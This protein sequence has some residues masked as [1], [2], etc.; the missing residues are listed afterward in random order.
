VDANIHVLRALV[1]NTYLARTETP[2]ATG[3]QTAARVGAAWRDQN[4]NISG[5]WRRIGDDFRPAVGFV[6]RSDIEHTYVTVGT[7]RRPRVSFLQEVNPYLEVHR[8]TDLG[9]TLVTREIQGGLDLDLR[10]GATLTGTVSHTYELVERPFTLSG[11][12]IAAGGYDFDEGS[13]RFQSSAGKPFSASVALSGGGYYGGE[14]RSLSGGFRWLA[15]NRLAFTGSADY[16]R[17]DLGAGPFASSVYSGRLK[18]AF[19][20]RAFLTLNVQYNQDVDQMVSY[21]RFNVIH[22]PL[23]DFFLVLTERRQMGTGGGV[24]ERAFT[25]K[26]TKLLAF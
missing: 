16:N 19:N 20:T 14:R 26:V 13:V 5:L 15:S 4:W 17:L 9:D 1:L 2:G 10:S 21:A 18:Y 12:V 8:Y 24:L 25:A 22:G 7:H 11:G 6:R 23:S 3:D